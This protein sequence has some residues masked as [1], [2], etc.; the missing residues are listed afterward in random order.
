MRIFAL[1]A[2][3]GSPFG[4][5]QVQA[6]TVTVQHLIEKALRTYLKCSMKIVGAGRTDAGV[7]ALGQVFHCD[8]PEGVDLVRLQMGLNG[9]LPPEIRVLELQSVSPTAHAQR[10]AQSKIYD[11]SLQTSAHVLPF[12]RLYCTQ[13]PKLDLHKMR[14]A[15]AK[16][17]GTRDFLTLCNK[18]SAIKNTVRTLY[19]IDIQEVAGGYQLTFEG[20]GFLYKMVRNIVGVLLEVARGK[21]CAASIDELLAAKDRRLAGPAAPA[22]GLLLRSVDYKDLVTWRS[23]FAKLDTLGIAQMRFF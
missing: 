3:D 13:V 19:R 7:H 4:G 17:V 1:T 8:L 15:A 18:G 16:F 2:Y 14:S 6:N 5:W 12:D 22:R 10:S 23:P 9:L 11:Y 20:N 21:R